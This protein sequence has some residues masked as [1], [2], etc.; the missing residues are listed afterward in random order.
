[1]PA[2]IY[3]TFELKMFTLRVIFAFLEKIDT[4]EKIMPM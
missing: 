4:T 3:I 1:M 2:P